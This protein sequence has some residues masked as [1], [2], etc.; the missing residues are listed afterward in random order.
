MSGIVG[1]HLF[2]KQSACKNGGV[3]TRP[4][5]VLRDYY[6]GENW[7]S[8]IITIINHYWLRINACRK[9]IQYIA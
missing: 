8:G 7:R 5:F 3:H 4:F 6:R 9:A 2:V 1:D